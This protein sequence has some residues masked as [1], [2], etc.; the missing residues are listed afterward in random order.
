MREVSR[1]D[2]VPMDLQSD[3]DVSIDGEEV[4]DEHH[5]VLARGYQEPTVSGKLN[6]EDFSTVPA[7][8]LLQQNQ[9]LEGPINAIALIHRKALILPNSQQ[10][11]IRTERCTLNR[12]LE[13]ELPNHKI[14]MQVEQRGMSGEVNSDDECLIG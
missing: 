12:P 1:D 3:R 14:P 4:V 11:A 7:L 2:L 13:V 6:S 9:R 5:V 8:V 10:L